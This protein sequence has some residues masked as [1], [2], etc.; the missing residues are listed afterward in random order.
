MQE[1]FIPRIFSLK[2]NRVMTTVMMFVYQNTCVFK[3]LLSSRSILKR[4]KIREYSNFK[5]QSRI[6]GKCSHFSIDETTW[7]GI[8]TISFHH[9]IG[10]VL[11]IVKQA[12]RGIHMNSSKWIQI[13]SSFWMTSNCAKWTKVM[14]HVVV[15]LETKSL[16]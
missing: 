16:N 15:I 2:M 13:A 3:C 12:V 5:F 1:I 4:D 8:S 9:I 11:N 14:T 10:K 6:H 7:T